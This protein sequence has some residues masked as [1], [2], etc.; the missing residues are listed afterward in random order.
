MATS[1]AAN[2]WVDPRAQIDDDVEIGPFCVIGPDV[3]IGRGTRLENNVT[4]MGRVD[5]R[6][7]T[8]T[9]YPAW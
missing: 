3:S 1:I 4:L 2:A 7:A 5:P 6:P 8:T 9:L